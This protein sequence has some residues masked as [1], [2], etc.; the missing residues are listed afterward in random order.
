MR[1]LGIETSCDE[2]GVAVYDTR[3]RAARARAALAGRDARGLRRRR[4]RARLARPRAARRAAGRARARARR[5]LALAD[6]DGI[7]YT[8]GPG[9]RRRAARRRQR[10][11]RARLRA[12]QAG[13]RR[14]SPRRPPA[15]AA[16]RGR[17]SP[18]FPFVALLVSGGHSQLLRRRRASGRYRL[19]GDTQDDAAGEAFD[20]TA[21]LLGLPLS[22]RTGAG[23]RSP[24]RDA[25]A[26]VALPRPMLDIGRS[27]LQLLGPQDRGADARAAARQRAERSTTRARADIARE[28]QHAVV[29]V[30]VAKALAA[31]GATGRDAARRRGRRRRQSRAAR[32]ALRRDRAR[33]AA[34][35]FYPRP[36]VLHRQRRD[37]RAGRRAAR[38]A[39]RARRR[40]RLPLRCAGRA[41]VGR[42]G[43]WRRCRRRLTR[44]V[45]RRVRGDAATARRGRSS[46]AHA[47]DRALAGPAIS[48]RMLARCR[49]NSSSAIGTQ[50]PRG[51]ALPKT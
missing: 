41:F 14:P 46:A 44:P 21:K 33:A 27:R 32:A 47:P 11:Q 42:A 7:A 39:R 6:L 2:T 38:S 34:Q 15:V 23:A 13:D 49:Q 48:W 22:G 30:L 12:R 28:F 16:A 24:R 40:G 45:A 17:R 10:R 19:L 1:V 18:A 51:G 9:T 31:L 8:Q 3:P 25:T 43:T 20:K 29:D 4:A 5:A 35:V 50:R 36:R 37:D 26:R